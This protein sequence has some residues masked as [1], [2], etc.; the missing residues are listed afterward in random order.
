MCD[1]VSESPR[2]ERPRPGQED[3]DVL[4]EELEGLYDERFAEEA[5]SR[6]ELWQVLCR[7]F[8]QQW[9]YGGG[10]PELEVNY[11]WDS[12]HKLAKV[13]IKQTQKVDEL[14]ACFSTPLD[15]AII[16]P[17]SDKAALDEHT[18][19]FKSLY[20]QVQ[21]GEDGQTEQTFYF[22]LEREP[23]VVRIDPEGWL[24]KTLKYERPDRMLRYQLAYDPD[25][26]GRVEAA[27]ELGKR[28]DDKRKL[29]NLSHACSC[30]HC[31][32]QGLACN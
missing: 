8:F 22:P 29:T 13:R 15:I 3:D 17:T 28:S 26:L 6:A 32:L 11:S 1:A 21:L 20:Y 23:L 2:A 31:L 10:Y 5:R 25:V 27:E 18:K 16:V 30:L 14:T 9:V 19:E 24:L 12:E 7:H 4:G